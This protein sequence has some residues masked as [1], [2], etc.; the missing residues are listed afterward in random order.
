MNAL[1]LTKI[2]WKN[3]LTTEGI[4]KAYTPASK[5]PWI[6]ANGHSAVLQPWRPVCLEVQLFA[7]PIYVYIKMEITLQCS[8]IMQWRWVLCKPP[9]L[10][11]I[12]IKY[13]LTLRYLDTKGPQITYNLGSKSLICLRPR[14]ELFNTQIISDFSIKKSMLNHMYSRL[15]FFENIHNSSA[16]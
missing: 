14:L 2:K 6:P 13:L 7:Q 3:F 4:Q 1:I 8:P 10:N 15:L 5:Q 9:I 12:I 16:Y 11:F